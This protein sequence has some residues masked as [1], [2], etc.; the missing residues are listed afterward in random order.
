[1]TPAQLAQAAGCG[2]PV[3]AGWLSHIEA[4]MARFN[5]N[6]AARKAAFIAQISHESGRFSRIEENLNYSAAGLL[7]IFPRHFTADQAASYARK[8]QAIANRVYAGR[9]GNGAEVSGDG[10]RYRG[11]GL[12]QI[13][14][15]NNYAACGNATG[16]S[17]VA[18]PDLLLGLA[19]AAMSA[20]WFWSS[21]G[22]NEIADRGDFAGI[23]KRINGGLI[24]AADRVALFNQAT[25]A[26][27]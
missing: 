17:L 21:N 22:C 4:A 2:L 20:A 13:T 18:N 7:K 19:A 23:T 26:L 1:M 16:L 3:A 27:A 12:I 5:I 15:L 25:E 8:P 14:G 10:W 11:R 6:T 24:G 9:M